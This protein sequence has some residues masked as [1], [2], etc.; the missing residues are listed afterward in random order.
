MS[1]ERRLALVGPAHIFGR[2]GWR[3]GL[4]SVIRVLD[5]TSDRSDNHGTSNHGPIPFCEE[6]LEHLD[7][8]KLAEPLPMF[9]GKMM[10]RAAVETLTTGD[11]ADH[12]SQVAIYLR[13]NG[14]LPPTAKKE[15]AALNKAKDDSVSYGTRTGRPS[16]SRI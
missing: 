9:G 7:D 10:S 8:S 6:A 4:V 1:S 15:A 2:R 14:L 5:I 13:L 3:F 11:W 12:Y 16:T